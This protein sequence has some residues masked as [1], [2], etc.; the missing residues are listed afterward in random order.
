[1]DNQR[2]FSISQN[3]TLLLWKWTDE[4][5]QEAQNALEFEGFRSGKRLKVGEK[6]N[7]YK[8]KDA[9]VALFTDFERQSSQGR[10]LLEKKFRF[11]LQSGS[12]VVSADISFKNEQQTIVC[13]G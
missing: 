2:M 5:S 3:G 12:K 1:M 10:F 6:P 13:I 4:R 9:D 11:S 8:I 7:Q